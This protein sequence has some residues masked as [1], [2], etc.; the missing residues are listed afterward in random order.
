MRPAVFLHL[1]QLPLQFI[2]PGAELLQRLDEGFDPLRTQSEF[3]DQQNGPAAAERENLTVRMSYDDGATWPV[4]KS[5][6]PGPAA[7]SS[8]AVLPDGSIGLLYERGVTYAAERLTFVR[9]SLAWL[10]DE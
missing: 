10:E 6:Y 8:L 5:I 1:F 2:D 3:L 7:Y 9:F 4:T